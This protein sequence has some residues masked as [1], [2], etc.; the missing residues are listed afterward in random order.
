MTKDF[1]VLLLDQRGTG[2]STP[3]TAQSLRGLSAKD[4]AAYLRRFRADDIVR[5][6]EAIRKRMIGDRRWTILGQSY[7]GFCAMRY[8]SAS[9]EGLEGALI[10]G[11]IPPLTGGADDTEAAR[12]RWTMCGENPPRTF[13]IPCC[14]SVSSTA[15]STEAK[16]GTAGPA[17]S[18]D[19]IP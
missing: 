16:I 7:G 17:D 8:L 5:D 18:A 6:A 9:P 11:G 19:R 3:V 10:T 1:R 2:L 14:A 13:L 4:Q 15:R 12:A